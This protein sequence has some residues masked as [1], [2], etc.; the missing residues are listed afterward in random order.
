MAQNE[1]QR[2]LDIQVKYEDAINGIVEYKKKI[3]ELKDAEKSLSAQF[4]E[5]SITE[6][7]YRKGVVASQ[8][9]Q[10]DYKNV[11]RE[12]SKE[13]QNNIK[14]QKEAEGSL[15][16]LRAE[17][18][19]ATKAY[20]SLSKAEREGAKGQELKKHINEI[21]TQLKDAEEETQRFYRNVGN[22]EN[23]IKSAL[24]LNNEFANSLL[25]MS[26]GGGGVKGMIEG[27]GTS[28][29]AFGATL[30]GLLTNPAFIALA[31][32]VGVGV[33]FKWFYDYNNGI[34]EATRL[35]K[36]FL[37]LSG[38][39]LKAMRSEIQAT[40]D[41]YGK[42]FKETL[43]GVD[44][45][46]SQWKVDAEEALRT[47]NDGFASG[48]DLN[49]DMIDKIKQYAP[50]FHDAG[51]S[52]QQMVAVIQ[53]TRSG[54]FSDKGLDAISKGSQRIREM[55]TATASSLDKI[56]I[57]SKQV[58]ADLESG[59]KTTFD[60]LQEVSQKIQTLPQDSQAVGE[61]MKDVFG[62]TAA[63]GGKQLIEELG[64]M[65]TSL[66]EVKK[67][68]GEW[69]EMMDKQREANEE[70]NKTMAAL[71]DISDKGFES[72]K[73]SVKL[74]VTDAITKL[75]KGL[76]SVINYFIDLYNQSII[77]RGVIQAIVMNFKQAWSAIKLVFNLIIDS[78]KAAGRSL[79]GIADI[80][81]GIITFSWDKIKAGFNGLV[82][83]YVKTFKEGWGDIKN[84][85]QETA[86]NFLTGLNKTLEKGKVAHIQ[87]PAS[88]AGGGG[89]GTG[90]TGSSSAG[91]NSGGSSSK[92][93]IGGKSGKNNKS[94][95]TQADITKK[96][97][98]ELR[99]AEDLLNQLVE[100]SMEKRRAN[101]EVQY[102]RQIADLKLRLTSE[103][104]L[105]VK[106]RDA[107]NVQIAALEQIKIKKLAEF[108][109]K[110]KDEAIKRETAYLETLI[111]CV[112]KGSEQEYQL[113][114]RK[115]ANDHQLEQDALEQSVM[116]EEDKGRQREAINL[117]YNKIIEEAEVAHGEALIKAQKDAIQ[118]RLEEQTLQAEVDYFN[119]DS[120][121]DPEIAKLR[122]QMEAKQQLLEEAQMVEGETIEEFNRRKLQYEDDFQ[123]AKEALSQKELQVEKAKYDAVSGMINAT[124]QVADAF[125]E[126]SKGLAKAAKVLSLAEIA[127][128]TGVALAQGIKQ[129]QS[130]PFPANIAAIATT[131]TTI[132][133]N[134][135]T[136]IKTV[137]SAKFA[138]GGDV[139]GPGT[140][141]SD[142]INARLSNGESVLTA[143]ATSMFAPALSA[144]NQI[145]GG[146]PIMGQNPNQQMGE[147]FLANA[148]ARGMAMAPAPVV[149]VEEI[150]N[151]STRVQAIER[152][153]TIK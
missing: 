34:L 19:N 28:I 42:D 74:F 73:A 152:L 132:L 153:S 25:K 65:T 103:K 131:V 108:D 29:K 9:A 5:G 122:L 85:G 92:N 116:T 75:L 81:E 2:I 17:L 41:T 70:L 135:A 102:D 59:S 125:G 24:G 54:I 63:S 110:A 145:G 72:M 127:I 57:S 98:E 109:I 50:A 134:V 36:E 113:Q 58:Q 61:V 124:M 11:V 47:M 82:D 52:A 77:F 88:I 93:G 90:S 106:M 87:I 83:N 140:G 62:K 151:V 123:K 86:N 15:R 126:D 112:E 139:T 22:Y 56:G 80:L 128:N 148:V 117:K 64:K 49:G 32:I 10:K 7:E 95:T 144:F 46:T 37:G 78:A 31:G 91:G 141:T 55:S 26:Q 150:N 94:T 51:M 130:V 39:R 115:I 119:G 129:A 67:S 143:A 6:D 142:S 4:K 105:T 114:L 45:I 30:M 97:A 84:F 35:T 79:K 13:V 118:K 66:D 133:A 76:I 146:V 12:L 43:E 71:F 48:A 96:E 16:G 8:E 137:K 1:E 33:A 53:Q 14:H 3:D 27:A 69:G 68:T 100:D 38:D 23:S 21:T 89:E 99:K 149:S 20:D 138:T 121:E 111:A 44:T 60:V 147:E 104:N 40:A 107:I 101:I 120:E 18:S 136:A